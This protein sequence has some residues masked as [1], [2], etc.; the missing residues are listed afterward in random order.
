MKRDL[1]TITDTIRQSVSARDAAQALGIR[2]NRQGRCQCP[3]HSGTDYNMRLYPGDGGYHCFVCNASGD[4]IH[5]VENVQQCSF[6]SAVEWL[7][8]AFHLG[9]P[10]DRPLD[11]NA[12][13]AARRAKE[14]KQA[15]REQK[16]A[17]ERMEFDL[18]C[19]AGQI[20]NSLESD[21]ER[22]RPK[23]ADEPWDKRFVDAVRLLPEARE[24]AD[25]LAVEVIGVK[26]DGGRK[27]A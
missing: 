2:V 5:L 3:I 20:V 25:R 11:K 4:V 10:L 18:Y 27:E 23:R 6:L 15:E 21:I 17:I 26:R 19:I 22:Y 8:S 12:A 13:E 9:L 1:S 7:N 14:R 24:V 16:Q